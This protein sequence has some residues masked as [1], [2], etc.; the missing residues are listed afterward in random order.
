MAREVTIWFT[1]STLKN[2]RKTFIFFVLIVYFSLIT[3]LIVYVSFS[4]SGY[5]SFLLII[6]TY[7][8]SRYS[9][10][11]YLVSMVNH[12]YDR[13]KNR[14]RKTFFIFHHQRNYFDHFFSML[15]KFKS[16]NLIL[17]L[18]SIN[19]VGITFV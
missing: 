16:K 1:T 18:M 5:H 8:F 6:N 17:T 10:Y 12:D 7:F 2:K 19:N 11:L 3:Y 9:F 13:K 14:R 4:C 15:V